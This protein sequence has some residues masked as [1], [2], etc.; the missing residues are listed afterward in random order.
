ELEAL[1]LLQLRAFGPKAELLL[2]RDDMGW[3]ARLIDDTELS[4]D[5]LALGT[6]DESYL[7]WGNIAT[8]A[9]YGF[10]ALRDGSQGFRHIIPLPNLPRQALPVRLRVRHYL[11]DDENS[12]FTRIVT[13]RL[14]DLELSD[15]THATR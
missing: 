1:T 5:A 11:G 12:G 2:W 9:D 15:G 14:V 3:K 6:Y 13:S 4:D 7:L 8:A 10:T